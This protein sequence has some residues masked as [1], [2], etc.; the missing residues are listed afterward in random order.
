MPSSSPVA[1]IRPES[2]G[3]HAA[4]RRVVAAAFGSPAEADLVERIRAAPEYVAEMALVA[5]LDDALVGHVMISHARLRHVGGERTISTLSPLA[6]RPDRQ[7]SGI[8]SALVRA[9]L[10]VADERG[11]HLVVVEGS[12]HYYGRLGFEPALRYG[13]TM[14]L[15]EWAPPDAAQVARLGSFD[16]DD[17][18]LRGTVVYP[19]AFDGMG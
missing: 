19:P 9:V 2:R 7:R 14:H 18:T 3:D 15:P 16:P 10:D 4:I 8:G 17:P 5:V 11:E 12:P 6:V 13:I 1:T